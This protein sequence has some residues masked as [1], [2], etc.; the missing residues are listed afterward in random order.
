MPAAVH[1]THSGPVAIAAVQVQGHRGKV[2]GQG[3]ATVGDG[4]PGPYSIPEEIRG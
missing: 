3:V 4:V 1:S 2:I